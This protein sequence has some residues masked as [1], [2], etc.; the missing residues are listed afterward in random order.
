MRIALVAFLVSLLAAACS[1]KLGPDKD[2]AEG[3]W[4]LVELREVPVQI[5]GNQDKN[6]HLEFYPSS[7]TYKGFGGCHPISGNYDV[8]KRSIRFRPGPA[9]KESCPDVPFEAVFLQT[10]YDIDSYELNGDIM[11]LKDGRKTLI[12]LQRK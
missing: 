6:A 8:S 10:L 11:S 7:R 4:L 12:K 1:P 9:P 5:S 3:R 2:W